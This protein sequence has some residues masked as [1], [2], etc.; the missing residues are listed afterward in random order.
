MKYIA[1]E[2]NKIEENVREV[3]RM[4]GNKVEG[5]MDWPDVDSRHRS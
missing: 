2:E 3:G 5:W 4:E 1:F